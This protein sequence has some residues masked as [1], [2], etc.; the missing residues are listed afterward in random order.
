M[1]KAGNNPS[2]NPANGFHLFESLPASAMGEIKRVSIPRTGFIYL[3]DS[4]LISNYRAMV[5]IPRTGFIYLK[6][7]IELRTTEIVL[8]QSRER[9]SFI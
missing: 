4:T 2:F 1:S 7:N 6:D 8:F 5:S 9:V 3:K